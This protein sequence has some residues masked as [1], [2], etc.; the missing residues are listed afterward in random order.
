MKTI[1]LIQC[2]FVRVSILLPALVV[3]ADHA[4]PLPYRNILNKIHQ[5][6]AH[7]IDFFGSLVRWPAR[8]VPPK[9]LNARV[10]ISLG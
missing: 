3:A 4:E 10:E 2:V 5:Q 1:S 6:Y 7:F 8:T 9:S